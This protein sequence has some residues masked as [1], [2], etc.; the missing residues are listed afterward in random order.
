MKLLIVAVIWILIVHSKHR[1]AE[2][3]WREI[4]HNAAMLERLEDE[5]DRRGW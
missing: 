1:R 2:N 4:C 3:E 5:R